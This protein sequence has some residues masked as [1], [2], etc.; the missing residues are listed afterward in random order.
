MKKAPWKKKY[1]ICILLLFF[2]L[3][4]LPAIETLTHSPSHTEDTYLQRNELTIQKIALPP[5]LTIDMP[6]EETISRRM[7]IREFTETPVTDEE[8]STVLWA[9]YGYTTDGKRTVSAF[10]AS[11]A[12][13]IYILKE[14]AVYK[15]EPLSHFLIFHKEGDY[16]H[17]ID[18]YEAPIQLG[19]IWNTTQSS[20]ENASGAEIGAI[21][22]NIQFAANALELG[23]VVT[24][25]I[26]SPLSRID[27]PP[28][29][30]GRIVM[31]L[32]HPEYPYN[33]DYKPMWI[34]LLP[35]M[36]FSQ[37]SLTTALE[38]KTQ[39]TSWGETE[40]SRHEISQ[41]MWSAYGYSY[42]LDKSQQELN[43]VKRHRTVPSAHGYYPLEIYGVT[44]SG[45]FKYFANIAPID[46][47]GLPLVS[48]YWPV[49]REDN[50]VAVADA[51]VTFISNA[52]LIIICVLNIQDTITSYDDLS[53]EKYRWIWAYE[54]GAAAHNVQVG[55]TAWNLA[56]YIAPITDKQALCTLLH[57]DP[58][59]FEPLL[60]IA[61]GPPS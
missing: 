43:P 23:T 32:G 52:P 39:A 59:Q 19:L 36:Q 37:M 54:A 13:E 7:S 35:R 58:N 1:A 5:P 16:R 34:S 11:H 47:W 29:E 61:V 60:T 3:T 41:M 49:C 48:F 22:Q 4:L 24:A 17:R 53:A 38:T 33:F 26:P 6:L 40:L 55:A 42:Y 2:G 44:D 21:G 12:A 8:L 14:E 50:R 51:S 9:A 15:Y 31:P 27:L 57:L 45:T 25:E 46:L 10:D 18:Q 56:S 28:H 30:E 20:N